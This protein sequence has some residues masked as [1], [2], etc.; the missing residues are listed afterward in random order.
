MAKKKPKTNIVEKFRDDGSLIYKLDRVKL[1]GE[2][3]INPGSSQE[4][5]LKQFK[6]EG[7]STFPKALY[8]TGH[9][10]KVSGGQLLRPLREKYGKKLH[11]VLSATKPSGVSRTKTRVNVTV[12]ADKLAQVNR[13]VSDVKRAGTKKLVLLYVNSCWI[14]SPK[15][16]R[17]QPLVH[18]NTAPTRLLSYSRI[19]R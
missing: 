17:E 10:F 12:N 3:H 16:L 15:K 2:Y 18:S 1:R 9:G 13:E 4:K 11:L 7:F 14:N 5:Y 6:F 8:P 19:R